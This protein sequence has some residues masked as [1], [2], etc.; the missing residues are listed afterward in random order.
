[1]LFPKNQPLF[2]YFSPLAYLGGSFT[3]ESQ[4][5]STASTI[6]INCSKSTGFLIYAFTCRLYALSTSFSSSEVVRITTGILTTSDDEKDVLKAYNLHVNAYI[7]KP[8]D[9]EQFMRIVEA[10][11]EFWLS[12]VKLPPK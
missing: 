8:V 7:K 5:S 2:G 12:V 9:L 3:T 10:V 1:M 4:N 11:E 6:L